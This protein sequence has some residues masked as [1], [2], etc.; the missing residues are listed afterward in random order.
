MSRLEKINEELGLL[1][2]DKENKPITKKEKMQYVPITPGEVQVINI[3]IISLIWGKI[4]KKTYPDLADYLGISRR[5]LQN[6]RNGSEYSNNGNSLTNASLVKLSKKLGV[7]EDV[8][9]AGEHIWFPAGNEKLLLQYRRLYLL[10]KRTSIYYS[11]QQYMNGLFD[12]ATKAMI[13]KGRNDVVEEHTKG[14]AID[15]KNIIKIDAKISELQEKIVEKLKQELKPITKG[16]ISNKEYYKVVFCA[17]KFTSDSFKENDRI[18][19]LV[20]ELESFD[21]NRLIG[22]DKELLKK[23]QKALRNQRIFVDAVLLADENVK[24]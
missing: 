17:I 8:V 24:K 23:Y 2:Y 11:A 10:R 12:D 14:E 13:Q 5:V 1:N 3:M 4:L 18:T 7:P 19:E 6:L 15:H 16:D 22:V 21:Y 9:K 20:K